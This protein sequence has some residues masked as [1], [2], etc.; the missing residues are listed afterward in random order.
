MDTLLNVE[1]K[2]V[3]D[4][5]IEG[6]ELHSHHPYAS[7]KLEHGEE[8]RISV[9]HQD[10]YTLPSESFLYIE[11]RFLKEDGSAPPLVAKL[12]QNAFAFLFEEIRY[13]ICGAEID[14]VKN[15]GIAGTLKGLASIK[16]ESVNENTRWTSSDSI[17]LNITSE[18]GHFNVCLPLNMLFGFAE[19]YRKIIVKVKQELILIRSRRDDN[20]YLTKA[21]TEGE[22][23]IVEIAKIELQTISWKMPYLTLNDYNRLQLLRQLK[24]EK[25]I[26]VPFR[27]WE[28]YEYPLLPASQKQLWS[29]K[30]STQLEKPRFIILAFQT[31]RKSNPENNASNFDHCELTSVKLFLNSKSYPY[32]DL[33]INFS[34]NQFGMLYYMYTNF[35]RSFFAET[36]PSPLLSLARYKNNG[37]IVVIDC[38][39]QCESVKSG[40]VDVRLEFEASRAFP[41]NTT[42][43][44]LVIHDRVLEYNPFSNIVRKML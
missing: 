3:F 17:A 2:P 38:T 43:Y 18:N 36:H 14:R 30:T 24:K 15:P 28:L 21:V 33:N 10:I 5:C 32:K 4:E 11:G 35:Q 40:P 25:A 44:C 37:P 23:R 34:T 12:T 22:N 31:N 26:L 9:Q 8:I 6:I 7:T 41:E 20:C 39:K 42:A 16:K 1:G 13:E 27:S 29:V 19:D